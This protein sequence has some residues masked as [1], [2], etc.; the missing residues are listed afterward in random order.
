MSDGDR[1]PAR[2][3]VFGTGRSGTEIVRAAA[4]RDD[5]ELVGGVTVSPEKAGA[6]LG[7]LTVGERLGIEVVADLDGL[8][9][10]A[11]VDVVLH[12]GVGSNAER[13]AVL[14]RCAAAGKDAITVAGMVH[15]PTAIGAAAAAELDRTAR[16]GGGR[17]VGTGVN[18]GLLLDTLPA[19]LG[20][21][22]TRIDHIH[23]RRVSDIRNWGAGAL[24]TEVGLGLAP[25]EIRGAAGLALDESL[26]LIGD[27][28]GLGLDRIEDVHE[29]L[30]APTAREHAGRRVE[31][32]ANN[33]FR[34]RALGHR[35]GAVVA[36]VEWFAVFCLDPDVDGETDSA[37]VTVTGDAT[38]ESS[39]TG[40]FCGDPYP[41]TAARALAAIGPLA[42][43]P[44][45]LYR[46]DQ[47]PLSRRDR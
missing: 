8:L 37:T 32:G 14:G 38:V 28:L 29:P 41:S 25:E 1:R 21:M 44:P 24:D 17:I 18:P 22:A 35:G 15:P 20:S 13:A 2:A 30:P 5:V 40:T 3:A 11:D 36:E 45:G 6:D 23:A 26:A 47:I 10:R 12:T 7:E 33:G 4:L 34:R 27:A 19:L 43:M 42:S 46:P 16:E 31:V 39:A 9:A